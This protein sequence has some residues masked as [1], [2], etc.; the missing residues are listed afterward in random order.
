MTDIDTDLY[1]IRRF[2][3]AADYMRTNGFSTP[4]F[5]IAIAGILWQWFPAWL[6]FGWAAAASLAQLAMGLVAHM[7]LKERDNPARLRIWRRRLIVVSILA[8]AIFGGAI[9]GFYLPGE[10]LNNVLLIAVGVASLATLAAMTS[11]DRGLMAAA[12]GPFVFVLCAVMLIN[13]AYPYNLILTGMALLYCAE[14]FVTSNKLS[15]VV[16]RLIDLQIE[17]GRAHV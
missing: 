5:S 4:L 2:T 15:G 11:P 3:M 7:A 6:V 14:T 9:L 16:G 8:G 10:R 1:G 12:T 17:I 13:E